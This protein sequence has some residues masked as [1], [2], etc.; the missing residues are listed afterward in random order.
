MQSFFKTVGGQIRLSFSNM[1][2]FLSNPRQL[3]PVLILCASWL[4]LSFLP[5]FGFN[6]MP[7]QILSF[8]TFAQG[9][10]YGGIAGAVGGVIGKAVFAYFFSVLI[11]PMFLGKNPFQS[12]GKGLKGFFSGL[13]VNSLAA[14]VPLILGIGLALVVYNFL[15]GN[16]SLVNSMAGLSGLVLAIRSIA[17]RG[18]FWW[19]ILLTIASKVSRG[20]VP[21][22]MIVN[23]MVSGYAVGSAAGIALSALRIFFLP[24]AVGSL[25]IIASLAL[26]LLTRPGQ[27]KEGVS[28]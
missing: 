10:L 25:L 9:G 12:F 5:A 26:G 4:V 22:Q 8:L 15:T 11:V 16:A 13:A 2:Q 14:V 27:G 19:G 6:P 24:Y 18:G 28:A 1:R 21:S 20:R 3:I 23:R 7:V 17:T